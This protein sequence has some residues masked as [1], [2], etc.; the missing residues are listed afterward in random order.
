MLANNLELSFT[1][2]GKPKLSLVLKDK[3]NLEHLSDFIDK[4]FE[5]TIDYPKKKRSLTANGYFWVLC[6][7]LAE[8]L[9]TGK[10][11]MY[12][13]LLKRY[14]QRESDLLS[15]ISEAYDRVCKS[16]DNHCTVIGT[17][18]VN[19]KNFIHFAILRG[20]SEYDSKEMSILINGTVEDCKAQGIE[21]LSQEEIERLIKMVK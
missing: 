9:N 21:T 3:N 13:E 6:G 20:S 14:G 2:E 10:N 11:E 16:L 18:N 12:I 1:Y 5:V 19:D 17:G 15:V 8:K 4:E 7:K